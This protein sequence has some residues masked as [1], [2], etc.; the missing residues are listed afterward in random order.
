MDLNTPSHRDRCRRRRRESAI[1]LALV[2]PLPSEACGTSRY[3][4]HPRESQL[5]W[6]RPRRRPGAG[7]QRGSPGGGG[8]EGQEGAQGA[9]TTGHMHNA[10]HCTHH[11]VGCGFVNGILS[12]GLSF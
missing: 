3:F 6:I 5:T 8:L 4:L 9:H 2:G 7:V 11:R 10:K 1:Q 12:K